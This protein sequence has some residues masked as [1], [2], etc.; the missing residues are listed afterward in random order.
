MASCWCDHWFFSIALIMTSS[1]IFKKLN[2]T[3]STNLVVALLCRPGCR[4]RT[5]NHINC[6]TKNIVY[7]YELGEKED[8]LVH[9]WPSHWPSLSALAN[10]FKHPSLPASVPSCKKGLEII[11]N[12]FSVLFFKWCW[13]HRSTLYKQLTW[14]SDHWAT[15]R[16]LHCHGQKRESSWLCWLLES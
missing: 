8:R 15:S 1:S 4:I 7:V 13:Y 3:V 10:V 5:C 11:Y 12:N 14:F 2:I 16:T 6:N 9:L